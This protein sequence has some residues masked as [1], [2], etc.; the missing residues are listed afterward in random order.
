MN[1]VSCAAILA[2]GLSSRM[3]QEKALIE[4]RSQT[5]IARCAQTLRPI[6]SE[7]VV[8]TASKAV[9]NAAQIPAI[10]DVFPKKGPLGGIHAPLTH[11]QKPVFCVACDMPFLDAAFIGFLSDKLENFDAVVPKSP[12]GLEPLHAIYAP[13][14]APIFERFLKQEK[15]PSLQRM[16][17]GLNCRI[18]ETDNAAYFENWNAPSDV[19]PD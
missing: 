11:F 4:F 13:S 6:F 5:L 10:P 17:E 19:R 14:C 12:N 16:I 18:I 7:I 15:V 3:K 2:G 8:V 9:Q 1:H